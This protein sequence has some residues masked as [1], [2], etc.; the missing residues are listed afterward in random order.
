MMTMMIVK[1]LADYDKDDYKIIDML[2]CLQI[3]LKLSGIIT[4]MVKMSNIKSNIN[5]L[6]CY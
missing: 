4:K 3:G 5:M 1:L 6:I 2:I